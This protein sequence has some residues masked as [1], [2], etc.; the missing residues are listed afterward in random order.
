[1]TTM[2]STAEPD[3][4]RSLP[5][6]PREG[7]VEWGTAR[8]C[9]SV[10]DG[11]TGS[12]RLRCRCCSGPRGWTGGRGRSIPSCAR[13]ARLVR[14]L[15]RGFLSHLAAVVAAARQDGVP[16]GSVRRCPALDDVVCGTSPGVTSAGTAEVKRS[17]AENEQL[18]EDQ[19]TLRP[20]SVLFAASSTRATSDPGV[21]R[22]DER[23]GLRGLPGLEASGPYRSPHCHRCPGSRQDPR[24]SHA[25]DR[26]VRSLPPRREPADVA[27]ITTRHPGNGPDRIG[28][29]SGAL[30]NGAA[31]IDIVDLGFST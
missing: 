17:K 4:V 22:R 6:I 29:E 24:S 9:L 18:C 14:E 31:E 5:A 7:E 23:R 25:S 27:S 12:D 2:S 28:V 8:F 16:W 13:G 20:A 30:K 19:E 21:Q 10:L 3:S 26:S 11:A 1:M 15:P